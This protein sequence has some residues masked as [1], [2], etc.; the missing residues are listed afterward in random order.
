MFS[1]LLCVWVV[2]M[3]ISSR[4]DEAFS[5]GDERCFGSIAEVAFVQVTMGHVHIVM[6][7]AI[8]AD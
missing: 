6:S 5:K 4:R 3:W 8:N 7:L 1:E 2:V